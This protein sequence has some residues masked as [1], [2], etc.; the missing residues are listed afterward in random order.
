MQRSPATSLSVCEFFFAPKLAMLVLALL[1]ISIFSFAAAPDRITG[2]IAGQLVKLPGGVPLKAQ[3]QYDQGPVDPALKLGYM[4][5]LTVPTA[6]QQKALKQLLAQQQDRNSALFHQWLTPEQYADQFGLSSN[7]IQKLT[8]W[9]QSQGFSV[10]SV[11]RARNFIVFSG[12]AAQAEAVFQTQIHKFNTNGR[13]SFSN[14]TSPSIPAAL[15]GVVSGIRGLSNFR[16]KSYLQHKTPEYSYPVTG[17]YNLYLA[18]GDIATIYDLN[19]LYG[20]ATPIIGTNQTLAVMGETDV[21]LSDIND[22][23][24]GFGLSTIP[25][26]GVGS[27]ST[28]AS[29]LIIPPCVTAN[30]QYVLVNADPGTP[31]SADDLG[32]AD[33]DIEWS[34]A[35]A[36]NAQI[37]FVNAPDPNGNGVWDAWYYAVSNKVSPVITMSYGVCEL[38]EGDGTTGEGN[39]IPDEAELTLANSEGI[40]FMNSSGD[41][42]ATGCDNVPPGTT[43]TFSPNPPYEAAQYGQAV[44]YPASSPEVTGVGGTT[45]TISEISTDASTYWTT[46][47]GPTG[48][49]AISYIPEGAW[50]DDA[51]IG[52]YCAANPSDTANCDPGGSGQVKITNQKTF[53]EDFWISSTG[54]GPSN[55]TTVNGDDV[56]TGGFAQPSYQQSLNVSGQTAARF[57]PDVA[58]LA[59]PDFPGYI[60]CSDG[61]CAGGIPAAIANGSIVGGTSAASPIFAGIVTLLNQYVV[62]NGL[63]TKPGFGNLNPGLYQ[64]ATYYDNEVASSLKAFNAISASDFSANPGSNNVYCQDGTPNGFPKA[65]LCPSSGTNAGIIGYLSSS[66]DAT[67][68]YNLVTGLGSADANN[69]ATA[70]GDLYVGTTTTI[71]GG[72]Q[73]F[74]GESESLTVT[75]ASPSKPSTASGV[76]SFTNNGSAYSTPIT[77]TG[78]TGTLNTSGLPEGANKLIASYTGI[79]SNSTSNSVTVNVSTPNFTLT[80]TTATLT[81]AQGATAGPDAITVSSTNGFVTGGV[82]AE[83]L[84]YSCSGLPSESTCNFTPAGPTT[85]AVSVSVTTTAPSSGQL[86]LPVSRSRQIFYAMLLPGLFGIVLTVGSRK[87]AARGLR[88]LGIVVVLGVSTMWLA[89][90]GGGSS[91]GGGG[92]SNPGTPQ[93]TYP[94]TIN[95]TATGGT[96]ASPA[97]SISLTVN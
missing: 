13:A 84:T 43:Q 4:T 20:L 80:A 78:G 67:T 39:F 40:T 48:G 18:P 73:I 65:L 83:T 10:Q 85:A 14:I 16:A 60:F 2:P 49:S 50:N 91:G 25:T 55:C 42:G 86:H 38:G 88:L 70:V 21:Y 63:Q 34:G 79:Y 90:C 54:G 31:T 37:I 5:L 93:G 62:Q 56:C 17:G 68:G 7:D 12:T 58:M 3:A 64:I 74:L 59:S 53:Q 92:Q 75:V 29:G 97:A 69:L 1:S 45:L 57:V 35:V 15:S 52:A 81:V 22:F 11:A 89:S 66:S 6:S 24:G 36:Q 41:S 46:S 27:C 82:T 76:A 47:N 28:D 94:V 95:A 26:T 61:S 87:R 77:V 96:Q 30:L 44:N 51:E 19:P 23:R 33:L 9:L 71:T 72:T 8:A 32:E